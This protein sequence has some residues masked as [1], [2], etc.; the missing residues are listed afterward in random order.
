MVNLR[1]PWVGLFALLLVVCVATGAWAETV[2]LAYKTA[3]GVVTI[4]RVRRGAKKLTGPPSYLKGRPKLVSSKPLFFEVTLGPQQ[5]PFALVLDESKGTGKGYDLLYVDAN[6]NGDLSDDPPVSGTRG[7]MH[8]SFFS[9]TSHRFSGVRALVRHGAQA[10][11]WSFSACYYVGHSFI[12]AGPNKTPT[13]H[14]YSGMYVTSAGYCEGAVEV[15]GK[16]L[17]VAVVDAD[18]NGRFDDYIRVPK[19]A[20]GRLSSSGGDYVLI[21]ANRDGRYANELA[22]A[23]VL[24][25]GRYVL[26][27]GRC[28][29]VQ[30]AASGRSLTLSPT[31]APLGSLSRAGGGA[32]V[33]SFLTP[34]DGMLYVRSAGG[35]ATVPAGSYRLFGC[36]FVR[37]DQ[38]GAVWKA[39]ARGTWAAAPIQVAA[40]RTTVAKCGPPLKVAVAATRSGGSPA[41]P[42]K[43][44]STARL[45]LLSI[46]GQGGET[47]GAGDITRDGKRVSP[48]TFKV[49]SAAGDTV[50]SGSFRY[51]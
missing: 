28:Y 26:L 40:G 30:V 45:S 49:V 29:E 2:A 22:A 23:E 13:S 39:E 35:P 20:S 36:S 50:V 10:E 48:P 32:F 46:T 33:A 4:R 7:G 18:S 43:P 51:G 24:G 8:A 3:E 17:R 44:G 9:Q 6:G 41:D 14:T 1:S 5:T 19:A 37:K 47:Y 38:T 21:D 15:D 16:R 25:Y 11:P 31:A 27:G 42:L 12:R 34:R